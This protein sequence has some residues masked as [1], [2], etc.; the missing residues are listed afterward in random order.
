MPWPSQT[1]D[2][3]LKNPSVPGVSSTKLKEE[4]WADLGQDA[5]S[6]GSQI[7]SGMDWKSTEKYVLGLSVYHDI[8]WAGKSPML[9]HSGAR[10]SRFGGSHAQDHPWLPA[11][12]CM[13]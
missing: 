3:L 8:S 9:N 11:A 12:A 2:F 7:F 1:G 4:A 13:S 6:M 5:E 10:R